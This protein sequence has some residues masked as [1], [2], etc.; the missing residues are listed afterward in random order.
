MWKTFLLLLGVPFD[1]LFTADV[2]NDKSFMGLFKSF[3]YKWDT[4]KSLRDQYE[5]AK[6]RDNR[7]SEKL[8]EVDKNLSETKTLCLGICDI[9]SEIGVLTGSTLQLSQSYLKKSE[10]L[11]NFTKRKESNLFS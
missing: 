10:A 2:K 7:K 1:E 6:T 4:Y 3:I 8:A 5:G 9:V 11:V